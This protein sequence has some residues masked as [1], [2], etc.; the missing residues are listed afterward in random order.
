MGLYSLLCGVVAVPFF[1][2]QIQLLLKPEICDTSYTGTMLRVAGSVAGLGILSY[3]CRTLKAE[4]LPWQTGDSTGPLSLDYG[5]LLDN[6]TSTAD[7]GDH[8]D[9]ADG[10]DHPSTKVLLLSYPRTGSTLLGELLASHSSTSYFMEPL[11][12]TLSV[13]QLD[14][15]YALEGKIESGEV[16]GAAVTALMEGIYSC[17]KT[18]LDRLE[19]WSLVP[20]TSVTSVPARVC[21]SSDTLLV[22]A[23]RLHG[24]RVRDVVNKVQDLKVVHIVR[25]PRAVSASL[26]AQQ[27]EWGERTA[28]TYCAHLLGDME[29]EE[30][31]GP[32]RYIRIRYEDLVENPVTVL[33]KIG[34]F[35]G[36]AVTEEMRE[37]V[38]VRMFGKAKKNNNS[39]VTNSLA[40]SETTDYYSTTRAP[41]H[42]HN[43]WMRKLGKEEIALLECGDCGILMD[44]LGYQKIGAN[45]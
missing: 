39:P 16:P 29:L 34:S 14:W 11:F 30:Y 6:N 45:K 32:G 36:V 40:A 28:D 31:L 43:S 2:L 5:W 41:G 18:V 10:G 27:V 25:D 15:D 42:K 44:K 17:N 3:S 37:A 33:E 9:T 19:D 26:K 13:G 35:T 20:H 23:V 8:P 1:P 7:G 38:A 4:T 24:A 22:K 21:Q 12:A